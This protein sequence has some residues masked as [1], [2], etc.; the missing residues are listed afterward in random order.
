MRSF[1]FSLR[2]WPV[3]T[4]ALSFSAQASALEDFVPKLSEYSATVGL[5]ARPK[6]SFSQEQYYQ[7][8]WLLAGAAHWRV[9]RPNVRL[10]TRVGFE[11]FAAMPKNKGQ[12]NITT[13]ESHFGFEVGG[14][15]LRLLAVG[16]ALGGK[17]I[18][19]ES[20]LEVGDYVTNQSTDSTWKE[21]LKASTI[22]AWIGIPMIPDLLKL[23]LAV[24]RAFS[25]PDDENTS[26]GVEIRYEY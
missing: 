16:A 1:I 5:N 22:R 2:A 9:M 19:K 3:V 6:A 18:S 20:K 24:Q 13:G 10:I 26:F 21:S 8:S 4:C 15:Y 17:L 25:V 23:N 12:I 14:E 7:E 11:K